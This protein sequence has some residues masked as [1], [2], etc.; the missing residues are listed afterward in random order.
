MNVG[1]YFWTIRYLKPVQ[2]LYQA[3][4]RL[5]GYTAV[6]TRRFHKYS[7][8]LNVSI[9][10]LDEDE[11]YIRRFKPDDLLINRIWILN[12]MEEW[13]SGKWY[14]PDQTH[15]WNFNLH[16]FE[17]G[18]ALAAR[19][20]Q[21]G[22]EDYYEKLVELYKDWH[23]SCFNDMK[24]D[25]WH[26]YTTSLRV[27]NLLVIAGILN[28]KKIE[29]LNIV[30]GDICDQYLFLM[31][32]KE[33]NLL[34]NHYFENLVALYICS[35]FL[36]DSNAHKCISVELKEQIS[37]QVLNDGMH[38]ERSFLYHNLILEDLLRLYKIHHKAER[39]MLQKK[40]QQMIDCVFSFELET[41]LPAFN[42]EGANVAKTRQQLLCAA[43]EIANVVPVYRAYLFMGGYYNLSKDGFTAIVDAG[44]FGPDYISGHSHCDMLSFELF[45]DGEPILVNAGTYQ[46][47]S[48]L[49]AYFRST[50]AHN[51]LQI[52]GIEQ[53][54]VWG[55]HRTGKRAVILRKKAANNGL[56]AEFHD[57]KKN[58]LKRRIVIDGDVKVKDSA[59]A[60]FISYW[61]IHPSNKVSIIS[62]NEIEI[63]TPKERKFLLKAEKGSFKNITSQN[64]Y[65]EEFGKIQ[66]LPSF[67]TKTSIISL[68]KVQVKNNG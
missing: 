63:L 49:R 46:Y 19:Y 9:S 47:Q 48:E 34:G 28:E 1:R 20:K 24:S 51:T 36:E 2:I 16:Y 62:D 14:F 57:Y 43:K 58:K 12:D 61:H 10:T 55:E 32:N 26:P 33:K 23:N 56:V 42:D 40:I 31:H 50:M 38:F 17:F 27:K 11:A 53:S 65:S 44:D 18:I 8:R 4:Y 39:N 29:W 15:L 54:D 5:F 35:S 25:A 67:S 6:K 30:S 7:D 3:K 64:W 22:K 59:S 60:R 41:R 37:E 68:S 66:E 52:D 45:Y 21:T 13:H